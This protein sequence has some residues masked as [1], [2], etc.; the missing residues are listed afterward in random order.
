ML[1]LFLW[2]LPS[3]SLD[4]LM[5][6]MMNS[7]SFGLSFYLLSTLWL[8]SSVNTV[9]TSIINDVKTKSFLNEKNL[10]WPALTAQIM[11]QEFYTPYVF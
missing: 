4:L 3:E 1:P 8:G 2:E 7:V 11:S 10:N 9:Q 6:M 5:N